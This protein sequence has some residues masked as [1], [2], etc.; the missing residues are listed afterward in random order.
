[1]KC[2]RCNTE[3]TNDTK[4]CSLCGN[5]F[6]RNRDTAKR[7]K[8]INDIAFGSKICTKCGWLDNNGGIFCEKCGG[9]LA[10]NDNKATTK[11]DIITPY[12]KMQKETRGT[13]WHIITPMAIIF[14]YVMGILTSKIL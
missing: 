12:P 11:K 4:F 7:H 9:N 5:V 2:P 14:S 13:A 10:L 8:I 1:M 6:I 3:N